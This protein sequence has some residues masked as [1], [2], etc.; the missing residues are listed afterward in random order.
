MTLTHRRAALKCGAGK[1]EVR[2]RVWAL[3]M[4][5]HGPAESES[6]PELQSVPADAVTVTV[7][8]PDRQQLAAG[9][10]HGA[11]AADSA[12]P[13]TSTACQVGN[14]PRRPGT[15]SPRFTQAGR[16]AARHCQWLSCLGRQWPGQPDPP[17]QS[18][19]P[20]ESAWQQL[21]GP[22]VRP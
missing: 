15:R 7:P 1:L 14:S 9:N 11:R 4:Q 20:S 2:V 17:I 3:V 13:I 22:P 6:D 12:E 21:S 10:G 18:G 8:V 16:A 5:C 19:C